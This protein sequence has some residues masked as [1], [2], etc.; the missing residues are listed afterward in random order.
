MNCNV[1][2]KILKRLIKLLA[3]VADSAPEDQPEVIYAV[4]RALQGKTVI[5]NNKVI[6]K[7]TVVGELSVVLAEIGDTVV[8]IH[9]MDVY[10]TQVAVEPWEQIFKINVRR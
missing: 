7:Y 1:P 9:T 2:N 3:L 4:T 10:V 8:D 6:R 5:I